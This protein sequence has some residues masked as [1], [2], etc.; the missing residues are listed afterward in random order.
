MR[1]FVAL[2]GRNIKSPEVPKPSMDHVA[3][4]PGNIS[5]F[6]QR[7]G[8]HLS[9]SSYRELEDDYKRLSRSSKVVFYGIGS[10]LVIPGGFALLTI[11]STTVDT[12]ASQQFYISSAALP[13]LSSST[14][15]FNL[16]RFNRSS[17]GIGL[18]LI[19]LLG[20]AAATLA[21]EHTESLGYAI[22]FASYGIFGLG[23]SP[24]SVGG[25]YRKMVG[26]QSRW[27]TSNRTGSSKIALLPVCVAKPITWLVGINVVMLLLSGLR[28]WSVRKELA[29]MDH[30]EIIR[31]YEETHGKPDY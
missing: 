19:G 24:Y 10:F 22:L 12:L 17:L 29:L 31:K 9:L 27:S 14:L 20:P 6:R 25:L 28:R 5:S 21:L 2:Y 18:S 30:H 26:K 8:E 23:V 16:L 4:T 15:V 7:V 3:S 11:P 13:W 1:R